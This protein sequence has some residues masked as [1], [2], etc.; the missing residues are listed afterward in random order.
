MTASSASLRE[1]SCADDYD[2]NSM[3]VDKAREVIARFLSPVSTAERVHVRAALGRVLAADVISPLDVPAHDNSAMDGYAVRFADLKADGEV[4]LKVA[5]TAFA[6]VPFSGAVKAGECVR[7]MTGG[8]VPAGADTIVMQEH[9]QAKG[10][11]VRMGGGHRKGQ[12]LRR[13]GEDLKAGAV[14]LR[15]GQVLRPAEIGLI[16]SLGIPEVMVY[17][18]LRVAFFSTGDELVSVGTPPQEGQIYDSNR[19]TIYGM[20]ERLGCEVIDMGVVRDDPA[21]LEQAFQEAAATA[22]VVITSGGVSVGEA[23]FVKELLNKLGEVVFWKIAMKPGRPLAYGKIGKAHFFGLPGNP[24]SVMVTFYQFVR[25]ALLKLSG[26]DPIE[27]PPTFRVPCTS[28][29]KK[30]PG[31]T[32]FQRGILSRDAAGNWSVRV[33]GEQGSGILRS[34]SEA[35]CFII[36]PTDQG[37]VA[38]GALVDVQVMEGVI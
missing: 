8:V 1:I 4:T 5:G 9:V 11:Q 16:A 29:L 32:E 35:N 37:N 3:P 26:R 2:P 14:A 19:Y 10:D 13:A 31:R 27:P 20:L 6:G 15:R 34:M 36:L 23:D 30:A 17:R 22:D 38:P 18:R 7:I 12:N 25:D 24:V 28:S 21:L 33:T